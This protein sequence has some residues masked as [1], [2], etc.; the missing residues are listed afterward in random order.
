MPE[1]GFDDDAPTLVQPEKPVV[2]EVVEVVEVVVEEPTFDEPIYDEPA[3]VDA[4]PFDLDEPAK[5]VEEEP[6]KTRKPLNQVQRIQILRR[7]LDLT[8]DQYRAGLAKYGAAS[9]KDLTEAQ[10]AEVIERLTAA[11]VKRKADNA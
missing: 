5:P 3:P 8:E 10:A 6:I 2:V 11:I 4:N 7:E 9:S 1:P